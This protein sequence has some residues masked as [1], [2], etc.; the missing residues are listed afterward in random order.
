MKWVAPHESAVCFDDHH[1][2]Y[3]L[4]RSMPALRHPLGDQQSR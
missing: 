1:P 4:N 3:E 2:E